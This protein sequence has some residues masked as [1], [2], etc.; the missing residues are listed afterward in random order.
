MIYNELDE[1]K[2][3]QETTRDDKTKEE[4]LPENRSR[5]GPQKGANPDGSGRSKIPE[6]GGRQNLV[7]F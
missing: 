3:R 2:P 6:F 4:I 1:A 5:Q 7:T